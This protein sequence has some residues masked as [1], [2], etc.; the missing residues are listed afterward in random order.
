MY[1]LRSI[2]KV[3]VRVM[4][5][6]LCDAGSARLFLRSLFDFGCYLS[7]YLLFGEVMSKTRVESETSY[8]LSSSSSG[9]S[10]SDLSR[11]PTPS[12]TMSVLIKGSVDA[13]VL[14]S[15][16]A[17]G[18]GC[19]GRSGQ[20]LVTLAP[21]VTNAF[22]PSSFDETSLW[23]L[24]ELRVFLVAGG[25]MRGAR[26]SFYPTHGSI[27][28]DASVPDVSRCYRGSWNLDRVVVSDRSYVVRSLPAQ[29]GRKRKMRSPSGDMRAADDHV[30]IVPHLGYVVRADAP[31]TYLPKIPAVG[32]GFIFRYNGKDGFISDREA[33][34]RLCHRLLTSVEGRKIQLMTGKD[35]RV[36]NLD[37]SL[38]LESSRHDSVNRN[39][40]AEV[41]FQGI[42]AE[43]S[44]N[45]CVA[46]ERSVARKS[47]KSVYDPC[48]G[49]VRRYAANQE[50]VRVAHVEFHRMFGSLS[51]LGVVKNEHVLPV[52]S[53]FV[54]G[55]VIN[56]SSYQAKVESMDE[57]TLDFEDLE[58]SHDAVLGSYSD[59][60]S[61]SSNS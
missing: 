6:I 32:Q 29:R 16:D 22:G 44:N 12:P 59:V 55:L 56:E 1:V 9:S 39:Q 8:G 19:G 34:D 38:E 58:V 13:S 14:Y 40:A 20:E 42:R 48:F 43:E 31:A 2:S 33:C 24:H 18:R 27:D 52:P 51:Y 49:W 37:R 11:T 5:H 50:Q 60:P 21:Q 26:H 30:R 41:E 28:E 3:H 25:S 23:A 35:K 4:S 36:K 7:I 47:V 53:D 61:V 45:R 17:R 10:E 54:A 15:D 57:P 46:V